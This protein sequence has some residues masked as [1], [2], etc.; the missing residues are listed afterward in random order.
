MERVAARGPHGVGGLESRSPGEWGFLPAQ[1][2]R[3][4]SDGASSLGKWTGGHR[5]PPGLSL[6]PEGVTGSPWVQRG[7][8]TGQGVPDVTDPRDG[9]W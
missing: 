8:D 7:E 6:C 2:W 3:R 4:P 9:G 5:L 1:G